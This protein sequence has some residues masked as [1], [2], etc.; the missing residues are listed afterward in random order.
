LNYQSNLDLRQRLV[1]RIDHLSS[2]GYTW[3]HPDM[4]LHLDTLN[5]LNDVAHPELREKVP[6]EAVSTPS[7]A[8]DCIPP[9]NRTSRCPQTGTP[10]TFGV[11]HDRTSPFYVG[12]CSGL[13]PVLVFGEGHRD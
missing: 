8:I 4:A 12:R 5:A 7:T 13:V 1:A 9:C 2:H 10:C 11:C 6:V 3:S